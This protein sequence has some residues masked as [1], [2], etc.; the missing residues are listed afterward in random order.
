M[1]A[2]SA[3]ATASRTV[4][5]VGELRRRAEKQS[6]W[7]RPAL[8]AFVTLTFVVIARPDLLPGGLLTALVALAIVAAVAVVGSVFWARR[9]SIRGH[10]GSIEVPRSPGHR[11]WRSP[12]LAGPALYT[13]AFLGTLT[14][15]FN[16]WPIVI[17]CA[18]AV[19]VAA[20]AGLVPR[21][22]TA[23]HI[24]GARLEH[25]PVLTAGAE[26][27]LAAGELTPD[28]LELLVLQHHT[29]E[30]RISWCAEVLGTESDDIRA[31]IRRGRRWLEL[32]ATE[33]HDPATADWVRLTS[34]GREA[35]G[36][37]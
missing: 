28:V 21:Y 35:L 26:A 11:W 9:S 19:G 3:G 29:G 16:H 8:G 30:R 15:L 37:I 25:P 22:E 31:R 23:D 5:R 24:H 32:P 20:A 4:D 2:T 27:A 14:G 10:S 7:S 6:R 12:A 36:Y 18:V 33:V 34:T 13:L 17:G 1:S